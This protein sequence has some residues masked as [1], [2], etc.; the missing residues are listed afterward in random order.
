M[1]YINY[2]FKGNFGQ[3]IL[4]VNGQKPPVPFRKMAH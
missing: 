3:L 1:D 4:N 2:K